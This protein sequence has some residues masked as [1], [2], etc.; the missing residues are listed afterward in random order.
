[1]LLDNDGTGVFI[2][3]PKRKNH[4][5]KLYQQAMSDTTGRWKAWHFTSFDNPHLNRAALDELAGDMGRDAYRQE[6]MAEFLDS[7]GAVFR[8]L[9][10]A[11]VLKPSTPQA[12]AGHSIL[13]GIDWAKSKD[14]TA[15]SVGCKTCHKE[16]WLERFNQLDFHFQRKRIGVMCQQ[17]QPSGVMVELNSIGQPNFEELQ[18]AGLPVMGFTTTGASKQPLIENLALAIEK[19]EWKFL[20]DPIA[21]GELESY[22][23]KVNTVTSR[24]SYS[25]PEGLHDDTVIARA[26]MLWMAG[27]G[28]SVIDDPFADW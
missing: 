16:L 2:F 21:R 12:H 8:N 20:D 11:C 22:E 10:N 24:S 23:V 7:E 6:I 3:T 27:Q 25:A 15:I 4:A 18:R 14:Y 5:F 17:W 13:M 26:L 1:M 9:D 28:A 19:L